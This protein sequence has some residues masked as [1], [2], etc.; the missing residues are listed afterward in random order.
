MTRGVDLAEIERVS[1]IVSGVPFMSLDQARR[2]GTWIQQHTLRRVLELGFAHGVSTCYIA[3]TV[4]QLGGGHVTTIDLESARKRSPCIEELLLKCGLQHLVEIYYEPRSFTWRLM[5][6]IESPRRPTYDLV[7]L[8][9][10]H[11]W[12]VTGF[13]FFLVDKL[14]RPG[15]WLIFDDLRWTMATSPTLGKKPETLALPED[16]V[17]TPQVLKVFE[18]LVRE[19]PDYPNCFADRG[20]GFAQKRG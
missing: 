15:G 18:L 4:A 11:T 9:A 5:R 14:L 3:A 19:H 13:A 16:F 17:T 2:I 6:M 10:G 1:T 7:Y 12:D 8:D 20:W